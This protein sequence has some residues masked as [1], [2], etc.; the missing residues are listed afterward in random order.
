M[1]YEVNQCGPSEM[2]DPLEG[3]GRISGVFGEQRANHT[4]KGLDLAAPTE[5]QVL[6]AERGVVTHAGAGSARMSAYGN[7]IDIEHVDFGLRTRYAHLSRVAPGVRPGLTVDRG[8]LIGFVGSTGRSTGPHL[9][10]EVI[11]V[12][13]RGAQPINP[14]PF[15]VGR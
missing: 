1:C 14:R 15:L 7:Y 12:T 6:A 9:H 4:H 5:T 2:F 8:S 13:P 10:F 11:Q 3:R